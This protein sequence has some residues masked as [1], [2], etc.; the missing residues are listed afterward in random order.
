MAGHVVSNVS[1]VRMWSSDNA[2]Q[3]SIDIDDDFPG[4]LEE[5]CKTALRAYF[6]A[7][8]DTIGVESSEDETKT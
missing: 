7:L 6:E 5:T 4:G 2:L 8:T 3:V 1:I